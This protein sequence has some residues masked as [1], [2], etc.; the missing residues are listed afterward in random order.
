MTPQHTVVQCTGCGKRNRVPAAAR[1]RVR[2]AGCRGPLP[3]VADAD[4]ATFS[5]V[6]E[7]SSVPVLVDLWAPWCGPCRTVSPTLERLARE[8]AGRVKL[9]K[10]D[11]DQAPALARRF[12]VQGIPTLLVLRGDRVVARQTGAPPEPALRA[13]LEGALASA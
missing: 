9:V 13:W 12:G 3:W 8:Y 7:S 10:V 1:G 11:V 4:D 2:C 6:A 5:E